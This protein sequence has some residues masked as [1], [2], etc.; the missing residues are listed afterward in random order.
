MT[1]AILT[2]E[3]HKALAKAKGNKTLAKK[4]LIESALNDAMLLQ[5]L[6][7]P[8][9]DSI[10]NHALDA[11][12][13]QHDLPLDNTPVVVESP[14]QKEKPKEKVAVKTSDT[15]KAAIAALVAGYKKK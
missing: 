8:F 7:T 2:A 15:Q 1:H 10:A 3:L 14:P 4:Y 13:R 9:L 6:A 11:H 12:A 5:M